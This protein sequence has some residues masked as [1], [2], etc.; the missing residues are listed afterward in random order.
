MVDSTSFLFNEFDSD[1][2][3][4]TDGIVIE[5]YRKEARSPEWSGAGARAGGMDNPTQP[6]QT[7]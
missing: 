4:D 1:N 6:E 5:K 7:G 3:V 2:D